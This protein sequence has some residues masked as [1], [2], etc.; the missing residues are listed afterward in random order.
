MRNSLTRIHPIK[1]GT[2]SWSPNNYDTEAIKVLSFL[3]THDAAHTAAISDAISHSLPISFLSFTR[4]VPSHS[5]IP[6]DTVGEVIWSL[7]G[8]LIQHTPR[9][10]PHLPLVSR[11]LSASLSETKEHVTAPGNASSITDCS[12]LAVVHFSFGCTKQRELFRDLFAHETLL[13]SSRHVIIPSDTKYDIQRRNRA[14][15]FF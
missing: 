3:L 7:W 14:P 10:D 8:D 12:S 15:A 9:H 4:R 2:P 6:S 1:F 11:S 5:P 13:A